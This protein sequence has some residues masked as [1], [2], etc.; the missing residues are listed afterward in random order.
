VLAD[1]LGGSSDTITI[2][3]GLIAVGTFT[4]AKTSKW[5]TKHREENSVHDVVVGVP[6]VI[7]NGQEVVPMRPGLI[8]RMTSA[9]THLATMQEDV[10]ATKTEVSSIKTTAEQAL[11]I[12]EQINRKVTPNGGYTA[13]PGDLLLQIAEH[14]GIEVKNGEGNQEPEVG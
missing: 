3:V 4:Y 8:H 7:V 5:R 6:A 9:E 1:I 12:A 2:V 11:A 14:L 10:T 13:N